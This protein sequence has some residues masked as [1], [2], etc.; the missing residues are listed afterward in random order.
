MKTLKSKKIGILYPILYPHSKIYIGIDIIVW[1]TNSKSKLL[2]DLPN[3]S[4]L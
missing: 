2:M 3:P 1:S 4:Y